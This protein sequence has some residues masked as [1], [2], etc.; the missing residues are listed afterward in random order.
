MSRRR[1]ATISPSIL[2]LL[3]LVPGGAQAFDFVVPDGAASGTVNM[4]DGD[5]LLVEF[6]GTVDTTN[7]GAVEDVTAGSDLGIIN[8]GVITTSATTTIKTGTSNLTIENYGTIFSADNAIASNIV[9]QLVNGAGGSIIA[10]NGT[11]VISNNLIVMNNAGIINGLFL[12][13]DADKIGTFSNSGV[14]G[15]QITGIQAHDEFKLLTNSGYVFGVGDAIKVTTGDLL[16]L[17]NSGTLISDFDA[18]DVFGTFA[19]GVNS[20]EIS[21]DVGIKAADLG[22]FANSGQVVGSTAGIVVSGF[23]TNLTNSGVIGSGANDA[24]FADGIGTLINSGEITGA[25]NG[26]GSAGGDIGMLTN[27]G[28]IS[29]GANGIST[30]EAKI[31]NAGIIGGGTQGITGAKLDIDNSGFVLSPG[32][33]I[34]AET[35]N[36]NNSG[37]ILGGNAITGDAVVSITNSG[38]I[39]GNDPSFFAIDENTATGGDTVLNL[40]KGSVLIGRIDISTG[41]D[42]LSAG[43]GVNLALTFDTSVPELIQTDGAYL[44]KGNTV[45]VVDLG[46]AKAATSTAATLSNGVGD[47]VGTALRTGFDEKGVGGEGNYWLEAFGATGQR[48]GARQLTGGVAAGV[49]YGPDAATR[50]GGLIGAGR[51]VS[52]SDQ[53]DS[54]YAGIYGAA[55]FEDFEVEAVVLGGTTQVDRTR[56]INNNTIVGGLETASAVQDAWFVSPQV[57]LRKGFVTSDVTWDASLTAGYTG[58]LAKGYTESGAS[59]PLT[60]DDGVSHNFSAEALLSLPFEVVDAGPGVLTGDV[61]GGVVAEVTV[62]NGAGSLN[63]T[64]LV[65]DAGTPSVSTGLTAGMAVDYEFIGGATLFG[66][67][68]GTIYH[69]LSHAIVGEAGIKGA[70]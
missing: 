28:T 50:F 17:Q 61:R 38:M 42:T 59:V 46:A 35:L 13:V 47:V 12:A 19:K 55:Q 40:N 1:H 39:A 32:T 11:G 20:G 7:T 43:A 67:V 70:F 57:T 2:V 64:A 34:R 69:D 60:V 52:G 26:V 66:A 5:T 24:V 36:L 29:G 6:G 27:S 49:D 58:V 9:Y 14:L 65:F 54:F 30:I 10:A 15:G 4:D 33:A 3:A 25:N 8:F 41:M 37:T 48:N 53:V 45:Y 44:V 51:G 18:I 62:A 22:S 16:E 31:S 68:D 63:G 56:L 21:G 23:I